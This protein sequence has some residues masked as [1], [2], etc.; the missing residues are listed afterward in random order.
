MY[1]FLRYRE[2]L[3]PHDSRGV[4]WTMHQF[5]RYFNTVRVPGEVMDKIESYFHTGN[6]KKFPFI[7]I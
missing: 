6:Y 7:H 3:R 4:P 2:R 5:R 1:F